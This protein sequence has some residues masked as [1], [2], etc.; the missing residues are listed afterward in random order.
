MPTSPPA[1]PEARGLRPALPGLLALALAVFVAITTEMLPVGL[2]P[3]IGRDLGVGEGRAGLL[4]T[5]YAVMVAVLAVP[6]TMVTA[7][8]PRKPVLLATLVGYTLSNVL[9][10]LAPGF[11]TLALGRALGGVSHALFF[12][13]AIGYGPRL[14]PPLLV[15]R[16]ITIVLSGASLG[17]ILGVPLATSIG[18]AIGWRPAFVTVAAMAAA[19]TVV[20]ALL[21]PAAEGVPRRTGPRPTRSWWRPTITAV[22]GANALVFLGHFAAWTYIAPLLLAAGARENQVGPVL[23]LLGGVGIVG[24]WGAALFV[25]RRPRAGLLTTLTAMV[26]ALVAL[27]L[28]QDSLGWVVVAAVLW[29]AAMGSVPTLTQ[30]AALRTGDV[31]PDI[32][33]ALVNGTSNLGIA[34]GAALGGVVVGSAG[35][36]AVPLVA[37]GV[38]L[39]CLVVILLARRGFPTRP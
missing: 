23:L 32:A 36:G 37:A 39:A 25:D 8:L 5:V 4:V 16:A 10:A 7:R 17:N 12:S 21:L 20:V 22:G 19:L 2:L 33:G 34:V 30:A 28:G 11:A 1:S 24:V 35:V 14:V 6:M 3:Q 18:T 13:V 29:S 27:W 9:V 26:L 15:G 38:L 31:G